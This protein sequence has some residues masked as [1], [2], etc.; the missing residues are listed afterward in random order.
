MVR[1]LEAM[2]VPRSVMGTLASQ[3]ASPQARGYMGYVGALGGAVNLIPI[4]IAVAGI[5]ILVAVTLHVAAEAVEAIR[6]RPKKVDEAC[7]PPFYN[8]LNNKWQPEW[9]RETYGDKKDCLGCLW[10]CR[11]NGGRW[12]DMKCPRPGYRPN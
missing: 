6:R 3:P 8:C 9:N 11:D 5:T 1:A 2:S 7:D 10:E 12:P 4:V